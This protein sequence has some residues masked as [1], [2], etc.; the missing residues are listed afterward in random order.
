MAVA[1]VFHAISAILTVPCAILSCSQVGLFRGKKIRHF[2]PR[3]VL[4]HFLI[5]LWITSKFAY[6]I[7]LPETNISAPEN[8]PLETEIPFLET[9]IF[10]GKNV[11]F[12]EGICIYHIYKY[13]CL[14][15]GT[16]GLT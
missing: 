13:A 2:F 15:L 14:L 1:Q 16:H 10:R 4:K 8:R 7:F 3:Q 11:S 12:R 6:G 9:I 5:D